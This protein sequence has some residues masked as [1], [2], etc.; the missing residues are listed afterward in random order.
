MKRS[1][2][3]KELIEGQEKRLLELARRIEPE[4]TLD[5]LAQPNDYPRLETHPEFRYEEGVLHGIRVVE[6][7]LRADSE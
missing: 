5:D 4:V 2:L 1:E 7:A 6:V 3:F